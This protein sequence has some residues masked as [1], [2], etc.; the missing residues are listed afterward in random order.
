[1]DGFKNE[2]KI[3][4]YFSS[5][6]ELIKLIDDRELKNHII[7]RLDILEDSFYEFIQFII[8]EIYSK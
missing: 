3:K 7:N 5:L 4:K 8:K 1:M 6:R 2:V